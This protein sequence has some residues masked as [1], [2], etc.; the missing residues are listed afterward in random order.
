MPRVGFWARYELGFRIVAHLLLYSV[1]VNVNT[2][3]GLKGV[4]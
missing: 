2:R 3:A 1:K 4:S